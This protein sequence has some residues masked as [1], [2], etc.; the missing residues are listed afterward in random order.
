M[1]RF[2]VVF[3]EPGTLGLLFSPETTGRPFTVEGI[4]AG[5][6]IGSASAGAAAKR[7]RAG[8][9]LVGVQ[10]QRLEGLTYEEGLAAIR[11]AGRPLTL[12]F[13]PEGKAVGTLG[14]GTAHASAAERPLDPTDPLGLE[15]IL[16]L[17]SPAAV[18]DPSVGPRPDN[19]PAGGGGGVVFREMRG[20]A[21]RRYNNVFLNDDTGALPLDSC[22]CTSK[23]RCTPLLCSVPTW[24]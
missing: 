20:P 8:C 10:G 18:G 11:A 12:T 21:K 5:G 1:A 13:E 9:V 17:L 19:L 15:Y 7:V 4:H 3:T 23:L 16:E 24:I 2:N 14:A 6:L 22:K